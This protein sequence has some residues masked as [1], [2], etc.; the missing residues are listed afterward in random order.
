MLSELVKSLLS[1]TSAPVIGKIY[2][3]TPISRNH[4]ILALLICRTDR[5]TDSVQHFMQWAA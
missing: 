4:A 1:K 2:V 3:R 5:R